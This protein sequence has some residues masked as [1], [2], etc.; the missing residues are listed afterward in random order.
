M[1]TYPV[2]TAIEYGTTA[3]NVK[4]YEVGDTIDLEDATTVQLLELGAIGPA[5]EDAAEV[6]AKAKK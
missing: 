2:L 4:R 3:K 6:P 5:I 1:K